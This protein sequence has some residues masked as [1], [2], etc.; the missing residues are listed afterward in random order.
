MASNS[1]IQEIRNA[2]RAYGPA[3]I[4]AIGTASPPNVIYQT[5]YP[6]YYFGLTNSDHMVDLKAK[7]VR[8]CEKSMIKKRHF[9]VT[10]DILKENPELKGNNNATS[11]NTREAILANE[12]P[13]LGYE[14]AMKAIKEWGQPKSK[15]THL[16]FATNTDFDMPGFDLYFVKL[17]GLEP[18]VVRTLLRMGGCHSGGTLLRIAKDIA[19]NNHGSR[20][21]VVCSEST[22]ICFFHSPSNT[23]L[24]PHAIFGDGAGAMLVGADPNESINEQPIFQLVSTGQTTLPASSGAIQTR[25]G[26][27]GMVVEL[28]P[29]VPKIIANH[30]ENI[31]IQ[32][33]KY[34]GIDDWNSIFW[35]AH[36]GGPRILDAVE[37]VLRLDETK[38]S[39]S[40][41]MLSEY[42]NMF[43]ASVIFI[44]DEMRKSSF[45][46]GKATAGEGFDWGVLCGFGPGITVE[47]IV[48]H[49]VPLNN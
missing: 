21:L 13:K 18:T 24:V 31:L 28:S 1:N 4:L 12:V 43:G 16:L 29:D 27:F 45:K 40:R 46:E 8:I 9:H 17:L 49:S 41:K 38:L 39:I 19:E 3:T 26:E 34:I 2:Q 10:E 5:D 32:S 36:P 23:H 35:V 42:G 11:I 7:F 37:A 47:T 30:I 25:L 14:A 48:L 6:D 20:V 33:F 15:I 22:A 44:M